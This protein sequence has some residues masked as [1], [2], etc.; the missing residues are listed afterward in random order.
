MMGV[1]KV[2]APLPLYLITVPVSFLLVR[3]VLVARGK[4]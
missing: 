2:W 3:L 1:P 4:R